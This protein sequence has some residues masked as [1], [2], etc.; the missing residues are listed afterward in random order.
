MKRSLYELFAA[1]SPEDVNRFLATLPSGTKKAEIAAYIAEQVRR[2]K[3]YSH[4]QA[5]ASI[6]RILPH[7]PQFRKRYQSYYHI[8]KELVRAFMQFLQTAHAE[9]VPSDLASDLLS[10]TE[11]LYYRARALEQK[12]QPQEA[13][14][15]L[16]QFFRKL[17]RE[18][19]PQTSELLISEAYQLYLGIYLNTISGGGIAHPPEFFDATHNVFAKALLHWLWGFIGQCVLEL[20]L[21]PSVQTFQRCQQQLQFFEQ[22]PLL[23]PFAPVLQHFKLT[24]QK[25]YALI[26]SNQEFLEQIDAQQRQLNYL[27][28]AFQLSFLD[29]LHHSPGYQLETAM[30]AIANDQLEKAATILEQALS[31]LSSDSPQFP[32]F[33]AHL[34]RVY[35]ALGNDQR[36]PTLIQQL[37]RW[38]TNNEHRFYQ[39]LAAVLEVQFALGQSH[40]PLSYQ[41]MLDRIHTIE[42][43]TGDIINLMSAYRTRAQIYYRFQKLD[44]LTYLVERLRQR[45]FKQLHP[46]IIRS[47]IRLLYYALHCKLFALPVYKTRLR[48]L[49]QTF[50]RIRPGE[51]IAKAYLIRWVEQFVPEVQA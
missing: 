3:P 24:L 13:W 33:T 2:R 47:F 45:R 6:Y 20:R 36:I 34:L 42:Q 40:L 5:V 4:R 48:R 11:I 38:A 50:R 21:H 9:G 32:Y 27:D 26:S 28:S 31:V 49:W 8:Y 18:N 43:E 16:Q 30:D 10:P 17:Q 39:S 7:E 19:P 14:K 51:R 29:F 15:L 22:L 44:Q 37:A 35:F 41:A 1:A 46:R 25:S 23:Q 12:G